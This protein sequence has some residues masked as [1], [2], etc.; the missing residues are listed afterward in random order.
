MRITIGNRQWLG[1]LAIRACGAFEAAFDLARR[2]GMALTDE[3]V[4]GETIDYLPEDVR[5][6]QVVAQLAARGANPATALSAED[7]SMSPY[8][9]IGFMGIEI[10]FVIR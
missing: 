9:G 3:L 8:A 7:L 1:D 4:P 6:K 2:N 10:D 5:Q